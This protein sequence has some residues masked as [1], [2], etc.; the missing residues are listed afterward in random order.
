MFNLLIVWQIYVAKLIQ[1]KKSLVINVS[2][3]VK[4]IT[5]AAFVVEN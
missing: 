5:G 2:K 3:C 1:T 4:T